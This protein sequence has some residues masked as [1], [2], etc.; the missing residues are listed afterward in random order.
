M[1]P[2]GDT[3]GCVP[4]LRGLG[5]RALSRTIRALSPKSASIISAHSGNVSIGWLPFATRFLFRLSLL[6]GASSAKRGVSIG[7][8]GAGGPCRRSDIEVHGTGTDG[9]YDSLSTTPI[10][11]DRSGLLPVLY[12]PRGETAGP[13][14]VIL[15]G[16]L[17]DAPFPNVGGRHR[18]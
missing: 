11:S 14:S 5:G 12:A 1:S 15:P 4:R 17:L 3:T 8:M 13:A 2:C 18:C 10:R 7:G 16:G 6:D 9:D